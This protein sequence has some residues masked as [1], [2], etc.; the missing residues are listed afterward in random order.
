[1][2]KSRI[3]RFLTHANNVISEERLFSFC[4]ISEKKTSVV[5]LNIITMNIH[6]PCPYYKINRLF[7][8]IFKC[9]HQRCSKRFSLSSIIFV[10]KVCNMISF[11]RNIEIYIN[12]NISS[13]PTMYSYKCL[14][15]HEI[16]FLLF[17]RVH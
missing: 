13:I 17:L 16:L 2:F 6:F 8:S 5:S 10:W 12:R 11:I 14:Y 1:M 4:S 3:S 15:M 9:F 7:L